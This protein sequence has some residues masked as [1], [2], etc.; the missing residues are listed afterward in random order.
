MNGFIL[1]INRI[2]K[3]DWARHHI[4]SYAK[5][6]FN[7]AR[8]GSWREAKTPTAIAEQ[9]APKECK[10]PLAPMGDKGYKTERKS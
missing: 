1:D 10:I 2:S 3:S 4:R 6:R 8:T 9:I 7:Q 5:G